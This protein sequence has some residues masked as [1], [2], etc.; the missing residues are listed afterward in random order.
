MEPIY[1]PQTASHPIPDNGLSQLFAHGDA[2]PILA[3]TVFPGIEDQIFV[4]VG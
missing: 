1:L 3:Q 2:H 4:A